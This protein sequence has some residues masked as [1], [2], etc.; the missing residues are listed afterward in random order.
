MQ[1][2]NQHLDARTPSGIEQGFD[3]IHC[4]VRL[5]LA[6]EP[7]R[8]AFCIPM[9]ATMDVMLQHLFGGI[10]SRAGELPDA[11]HVLRDGMALFGLK[12]ESKL[13]EEQDGTETMMSSANVVIVRMMTFADVVKQRDDANGV[14]GQRGVELLELPVHTQGMNGE[15]SD[16]PVM[17]IASF[18]EKVTL[19]QVSTNGIHAIA[20]G[21]FE[22]GDDFGPCPGF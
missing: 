19:I 7:S 16:E 22:Q 18:R 12:L 17:R 8:V 20:L 4:A 9:V 10:G 15:P 13:L 5:L 21:P 1:L 2:I 3:L 6:V 14:V 11:V